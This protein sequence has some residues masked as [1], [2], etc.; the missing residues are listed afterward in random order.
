MHRPDLEFILSRSWAVQEFARVRP[1]KG[2]D[3]VE[4]LRLAVGWSVVSSNDTSKIRAGEIGTARHRSYL[5]MSRLLANCVFPVP[6]VVLYELME[7]LR[8]M[9]THLEAEAKETL[10]P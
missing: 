4:C 3:Y 6:E 7:G 5:R 10:Y 1:G 8:F 9:L 2:S